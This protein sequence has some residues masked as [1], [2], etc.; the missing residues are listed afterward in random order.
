[1]SDIIDL[2]EA[3]LKRLR[4]LR[5]YK[6][7]SDRE[8]SEIFSEK[9]RDKLPVAVKV[10]I[11]RTRIPNPNKKFNDKLAGLQKEF[12][13][14]MNNSNDA[15]AL[16]NLV[17]H[18]IQLEKV[19]G[20]IDKIQQKTTLSNDDYLRLEKLG[21]FQSGVLTSIISLEDKL[22]IS[23]KLR[24][25]KQLDDVPKFIQATLQKAKRTFDKQ[26]IKVM[27]PKDNIELVR[28]WLNFPTLK[29]DIEMSLECFKCGEIIEYTR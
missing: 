24:K 15:E 28:F 20:D 29:N 26:T 21:K 25:E 27:C 3:R 19:N 10:A 17:R 16:K 9:D 18:Q 22:G 5:P 4:N 12:N 11:K 23:R 8:I 1:M 14:D 7:K 2:D 13:I 6:G